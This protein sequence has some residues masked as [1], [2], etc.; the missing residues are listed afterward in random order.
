[1]SSIC[2]YLYRDERNRFVCSVSGNEVD[3]G[4]MPCL[5]NYQECPLYT[6][7]PETPAIEQTR[8]EVVEEAPAGPPVEEVV[9]E[10]VEEE[11]EEEIEERLLRDL[12]TLEEDATRLAERWEEYEREAR[13][14]MRRWEEA[15]RVAEWTMRA[16]SSVIDTY[17]KV[18]ED[19]DLKLKSGMISESSYKELKDEVVESLE[20]YRKLR[21]EVLERVREVE[22][23]VMP[24]IQRIKVSEAKPDLGKL[25]LSLMKLEQM[26]REGK[27]ERET[28]ERVK[29]ELEA[30]IRWLEQLV[31]ES[32]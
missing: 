1:M 28:Y 21:D 15:S 9:E 4:L 30:R 22:R 10:E 14:L 24:H 29:K 18:L 32:A 20:R 2:P 8:I 26:F 27:V 11:R 16:I 23:I 6:S 31:G 13:G 25:R 5:A 3:P 12:D 17:E 7:A 19:L